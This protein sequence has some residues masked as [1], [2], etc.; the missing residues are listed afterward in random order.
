[1]AKSRDN[2]LI[3]PENITKDNAVEVLKLYLAA[4]AMMDDTDN[5]TRCFMEAV[6]I[7]IEA[8]EK[9]RN[10]VEEGVE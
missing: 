3:K 1:M 10:I 9:N 5:M 6:K 8:L 7:A 4:S 2:A